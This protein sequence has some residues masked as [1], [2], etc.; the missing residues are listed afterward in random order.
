MSYSTPAQYR[1]FVDRL[2]STGARSAQQWGRTGTEQDGLIQTA[3]DAAANDLH[4][5]G[6]AGG[7]DTPYSQAS[8]G[9]SGEEWTAALAWLQQVEMA[10]ASRSNPF[11]IDA[12]PQV[13]ETWQLAKE[14]LAMLRKG[15]GLPSSAIGAAGGFE[16]IATTGVPTINYDTLTSPLRTPTP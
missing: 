6:R 5:A 3:L 8:L 13:K 14:R 11:P 15:E 16:Y 2:T 7:F 4:T 9:A 10:I 12:T 1:A